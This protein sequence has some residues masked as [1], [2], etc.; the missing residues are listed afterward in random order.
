[1]PSFVGEAEHRIRPFQQA[2]NSWNDNGNKFSMRSTYM[3]RYFILRNMFGIGISLF[4]FGTFILMVQKFQV[5][6]NN[7]VLK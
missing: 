2:E 6:G 7:C 1:L 3:L 4:K 5:F